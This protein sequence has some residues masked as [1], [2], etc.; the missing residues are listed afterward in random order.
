LRR[1]L[2]TTFPAALALLAVFALLA[3]GCGEKSEP[4]PNSVPDAPAETDVP[5]IFAKGGGIAGIAQKLLITKEDEAFASFESEAPVKAIKADPQLIAT[6]RRYL[7]QIDFASLDLQPAPPVPDE[8]TYSITY[9][10]ERVAGGETQLREN[11]EL[12]QAIGALDAILAGAA[13]TEQTSS[14]PAG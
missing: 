7:S 9:G 14:A 4:D 11:R 2:L 3:A 12:S 8:F 1:S 6:A 5:I 10:T 13:E